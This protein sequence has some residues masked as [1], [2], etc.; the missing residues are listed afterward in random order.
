MEDFIVD[1]DRAAVD[2]Y[3]NTFLQIIGKEIRQELM[4]TNEKT[5]RKAMIMLRLM[6]EV[7]IPELSVLKIKMGLLL[8][9]LP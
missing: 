8:L 2:I 1:K 6:V 4:N 5:L 9:V 7:V 3:T